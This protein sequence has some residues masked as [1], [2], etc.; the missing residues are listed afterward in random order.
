MI[1][2]LA[3]DEIGPHPVTRYDSALIAPCPILPLTVADRRE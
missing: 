3:L 1:V 2:E